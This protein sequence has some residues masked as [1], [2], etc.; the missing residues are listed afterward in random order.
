MRCCESCEATEIFEAEQEAI[1]NAVRA[2]FGDATF[3]FIDNF[4]AFVAGDV[5]G[6]AEFHEG[7]VKI[8]LA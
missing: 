1:F 6:T 8:E 5:S 3:E 7:I 4:Y 2:D